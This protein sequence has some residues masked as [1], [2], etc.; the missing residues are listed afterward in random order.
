MNNS[1]YC[2]SEKKTHQKA[3]PKVKSRSIM[4]CRK[5]MS[6]IRSFM[7]FTT[8]YVTEKGTLIAFGALNI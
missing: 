5:A 1:N 2:Y 8:I 4:D 6:I 7:E 3:Q